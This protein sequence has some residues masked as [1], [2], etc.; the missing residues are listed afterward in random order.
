VPQHWIKP[1]GT[2]NPR[3]LVPDHWTERFRLDPFPLMSGPARAETPPQIAA[4]D[5][6]LFHAVGYARLFAVAEVL[7][8]PKFSTTS[9]WAPRWPWT[10]ECRVDAWV[11]RI[12]DGPRSMDVAA[13]RAMGRIQRGA[14]YAR[15][16]ADQYEEC[17]AS[18]LACPTLER[19][20]GGPYS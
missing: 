19:R 18:L 9:K 1:F 8:D 2:S 20:A 15:L 12:S 16:T 14:Q 11:P 5:R 17:V 10:Y 6:V 13:K 3:R 4:G 7:G